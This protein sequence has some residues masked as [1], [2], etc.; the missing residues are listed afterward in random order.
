MPQ[1]LFSR[2][3]T[4]CAGWRRWICT[5]VHAAR[6]DVCTWWKHSRAARACQRRGR[7]QRSCRTIQDR[8]ARGRHDGSELGLAGCLVWPVCTASARR[9]LVVCSVARQGGLGKLQPSVIPAGGCENAIPKQWLR[10]RCLRQCLNSLPTLEL[11]AY[12]PL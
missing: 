6:W 9:V 3:K 1:K 8:T 11:E 10:T 4:S 7:R 5:S 2:C 12:N